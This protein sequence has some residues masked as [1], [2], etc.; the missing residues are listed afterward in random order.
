LGSYR[1][2]CRLFS[3][4]CSIVLHKVAAY[5][6]RQSRSRE[7][8]CLM[9]PEDVARLLDQGQ[10]LGEILDRQATWFRVVEVLGQLLPD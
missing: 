3:W 9:P 1:G 4:L 10:M 2:Q 8:L 6:W 7:H 5:W